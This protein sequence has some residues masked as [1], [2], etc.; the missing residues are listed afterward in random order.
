MSSAK[1]I[2]LKLKKMR[3]DI[4]GKKMTRMSV[5]KQMYNNT[6]KLRSKLNNLFVMKNAWKNKTLKNIVSSRKLK[7]P[8]KSFGKRKSFKER[9]GNIERIDKLPISP[10][11]NTLYE[12]IENLNKL[13]IS[14]EKN[15]LYEPIE[16]L[17]KLQISPEKNMLYEPRKSFINKEVPKTIRRPVIKK[18]VYNPKVI[19]KRFVR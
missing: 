13:Q 1:T 3:D 7:S 16:N 11:K 17:N 4:L 10:V 9:K 18:P 6:N 2:R 8:N 5:K 14:P 19:N 12:P 15:T